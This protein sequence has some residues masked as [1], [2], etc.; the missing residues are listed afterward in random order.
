LV[1]QQID[2]DGS[3]TTTALETVVQADTNRTL[4]LQEQEQVEQDLEQGIN[5]PQIAQTLEQLLL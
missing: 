3:D 5:V 2:E 4:L 1:N